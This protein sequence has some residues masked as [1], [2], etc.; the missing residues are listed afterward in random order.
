VFARHLTVDGLMVGQQHWRFG[1]DDDGTTEVDHVVEVLASTEVFTHGGLAWLGPTAAAQGLGHDGTMRTVSSQHARFDAG[2][3]A[4]TWQLAWGTDD[5]AVTRIDWVRDAHGRPLERLSSY[6]PD[7][8]TWRTTWRWDTEG[9]P[10]HEAS[11]GSDPG[12][13]P[14]SESSWERDADG[15]VRT[16][17]RRDASGL[18]RERWTYRCD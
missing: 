5:N 12:A 10:L 18:M 17:E 15:R 7:A 16:H 8:P 11:F 14:E 6:G 4:L 13:G 1:E 9:R 3:A 2:G